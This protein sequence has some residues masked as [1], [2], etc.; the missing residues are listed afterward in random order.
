MDAR[1]FPNHG[2]VEHIE[3]EAEPRHAQILMAAANLS[4][5][6]KTVGTPGVRVLLPAEDACE[7]SPEEHQRYRSSTM[8]LRCQA[9]DRFELQYAAKALARDV[10]QAAHAAL[11]ELYKA[12]SWPTLDLDHFRPRRTSSHSPAQKAKTMGLSKT[13]TCLLGLQALA[14]DSGLTLAAQVY[15]DSAACK[16]VASRRGVGKVCHLHVQVLW[17]QSAVQEKACDD[18]EGGWDGDPCRPGN[19]AFGSTRHARVLATLGIEA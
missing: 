11:G 19:K 9:Q 4:S 16:G 6:S 18:P 15:V 12:L 5:A 2:G 1:R 13:C 8:R 3:I 14:Q 10:I 7:L 17:V